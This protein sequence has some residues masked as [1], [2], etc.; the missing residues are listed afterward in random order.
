MFLLKKCA[1][2]EHDN[3]R[4]W[5]NCVNYNAYHILINFLTNNK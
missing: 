3:E 5:S 4:T 2:K 1:F